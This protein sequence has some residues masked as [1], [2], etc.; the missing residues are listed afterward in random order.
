V[1][2]GTYYRTY[3]NTGSGPTAEADLATVSGFR[4]DRYLVTVARFRRFV[5][6][7]DGGSGYEPPAGSGK[8]THLHSGRGLVNA[9]GVGS[10]ETGWLASDD[11]W[12]APT[13]KNLLDCGSANTWT[14]SVGDGESLPMNCVNWYEAYAFCIWDGGFLPS[15]AEWEYVAAGGGQQREFPWGSTDAGVAN[16]YAIY[17]CHYP[18]SDGGSCRL[19]PVGTASSG[20]ALWGELDMA[21]DTWEWNLDWFAPYADPCVDCAQLTSSLFRVIRGGAF[22]SPAS[23]LLP[24]YRGGRYPSGR[25]SFGFRCARTP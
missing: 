1:T 12:V 17:G 13:N 16:Q 10:Y 21:G 25:T 2:G 24:P 15:E 8:H 18:P 23:Y 22:D 7:W 11:G 20:A 3:T 9:G 6:A 4:L 19:A 14:P 5:S